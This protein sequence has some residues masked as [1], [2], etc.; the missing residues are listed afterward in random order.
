MGQTSMAVLSG[1]DAMYVESFRPHEEWLSRP[2]IGTT[3]PAMQP[4]SATHCCS[5]W[6]PSAS[7][8]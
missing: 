4:P 7:S 1:L 8:I 2:E 3:R 5:V 6:S